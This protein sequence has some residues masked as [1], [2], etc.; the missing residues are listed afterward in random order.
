M[1]ERPYVLLS[2]AMSADGYIDDA[3]TARL[4]L[5][6]DTDLDR[7]DELRARSDAILVGAQT[8]RNDNPSLHVRSTARRRQRTERGLTPGPRK[9]TMTRSGDLD[10]RARFFATVPHTTVPHTT[11]PH[12]PPG[13][14]PLV[15]AA[16]AVAADL[17]RRLSAAA[18]VVPAAVPAAGGGA[19]GGAEEPPGTGDVD[20]T[21]IL[22][23]LAARGVGRLMV[24]GGARVL[25]QFLSEGLADEFL[26][27]VA[28]F[29]VSDPAAPRLLAGLRPGD[30]MTLAEV[31]QAGD[32]AVLRLLPRTGKRG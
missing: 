14:P 23:D 2:A 29:F 4:V 30:R 27:A 28:P 1:R 19:G 22:A 3:S 17:S 20:L 21:W 15:Y 18:V 10:P 8:I 25:S 12:A 9:V 13:D 16:P 32:M 31:T 26:L 24:E 5:S 11:V 6:D 7:V